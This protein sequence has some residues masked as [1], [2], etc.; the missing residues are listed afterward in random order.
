MRLLSIISILVTLSSLIFL[1]A[2]DILFVAQHTLPATE[3]V[4]LGVTTMQML[5]AE[6][7]TLVNGGVDGWGSYGGIDNSPPTGSGYAAAA[8]YEA[9]WQNWHAKH[10]NLTQETFDS[11]YYRR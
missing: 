2:L 4:K 3:V 5:T 7:I 6:E 11:I 1:Q 9:A 8:A 10:P